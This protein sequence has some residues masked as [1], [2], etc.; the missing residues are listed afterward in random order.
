MKK[1]IILFIIFAG[2]FS[3]VSQAQQSVAREWN[4]VL[5]EAIRKD[6][7]RPT[8]H[9]RNLFHSSIIMYDAW[10]IFDE[11]AETLFLGKT[12]GGYTCNF[13][14][15]ANPADINDARHQVISYA[16]FRLL[17][18][19]FKNSPGANVSLQHFSNLFESFGYNK[20]FISTDY[21]TDNIYAALGNYLANEIIT[22]G[23]QD[24]SN[25][26]NEYTNKSYYYSNTPLILERYSKTNDL[27]EP[28]LWQPL[29]FDLFIDQ[30]GNPR[31]SAVP[32]FLSPEWGEVTPFSLK[33]TDLKILNN[34]FDSYIYNDPGEP[35]YIQDSDEDGI[36]DPY[37]W[38]FA[39][40]AS[41]STHL[42][43]TDPTLIDISPGALGNVSI[44]DFPKTF[45]EYKAFYDFN[46][47]GDI[48]QGHLVNPFTNEPYEPQMVKRADYAR[49]LAEFWADG[50]DSETPPG[51]W[52][53]IL[54][55]VSDHPEIIKKIEGEGDLLSDL[56]WDVKC[57]LALG[58]AMHDSAVNTWGVKG[59]Y[60]YIRP[61][62]AIRYMAG[63][64]QSSN[65]SLP[66]YDP[67][68]I[69]LIPGKIELIESGDSLAGANDE[70]VGR[71][72][73]YSWK[74]PDF[75]SDPNIDV[76]GVDWI[77][78]THWWPYQRSTFV[79][80]P[81]AGY[82]SGHSTFSR[83]ASEVLTLL[84]GDSFFPGGMGT[85][86]ADK[87][88]FLVFENGPSEELTLQWATYQDASDQTS[89]SR[90]W[91]GIHPPIDDIP[92]RI[93]GEKIGKEAFSLAR[94]YYTGV[95][96]LNEDSFIIEVNNESCINANNGAITIS[97]KNYSN[98]KV[99]MNETG[100][101]YVFNNK[102]T[103]DNLE[104]GNNS[105]CIEFISNK[106]TNSI[107]YENN[108][109]KASPL[110]AT[111]EIT[112]VGEFNKA[113]FTV[114]NGNPPYILTV[115]NS[116]EIK[117]STNEF[118]AFVMDGDKLE[119]SSNSDCE[120]KFVTTVNLEG[121]IILYPNPVRLNTTVYIPENN[122]TDV[123]VDIFN[124]QGQLISSKKYLVKNNEIQ[125]PT[126]VLTPGVYY[127]HLNLKSAKTITI[128]KK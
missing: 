22:F 24:G 94:D 69:P 13:E 125:V 62:S 100:K 1:N 47:G 54:N 93:I 8:V 118:E 31:P 92:G 26:E 114:T 78:G 4:E 87:E 14:G 121:N 2:T 84:T 113:S 108:V 101:E 45:E 67:Q 61:I 112:K 37:K 90:I 77:L 9:A 123:L 107:C 99:I 81:F 110:D 58:G 86:K 36:S 124:T 20:D 18:H 82:V 60:D 29:A 32:D 74:G 128:I 80:P 66:N 39:L 95:L 72:K 21:D 111:V 119:I 53:T 25:E 46:N 50:P 3:M 34:K 89:L 127:L 55:Y 23:L 122:I 17:N 56:E 48:G 79:T 104:P 28:N 5:L 16:M 41:W 83:A 96:E 35:V 97:A 6:Y 73:I 27:A 105:F 52:F 49:V 33:K 126:D 117:Y 106:E 44:Q 11:T 38:H 98:Y 57:Y 85:F 71:V 68:G 51:H 19:R 12:F 30:S 65:K 64:G 91:G 15:I 116:F 76:A 40:V 7:A 103:I 43:P 88:N 120:D 10:A 63:K 70:N 42:D 109:A 102:I 75:I 115:N 59:Y